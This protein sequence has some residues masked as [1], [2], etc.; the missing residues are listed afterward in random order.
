MIRCGVNGTIPWRAVFLGRAIPV[1]R[2]ELEL[3]LQRLQVIV[4]GGVRRDE[5]SSYM[6]RP[7]H[8]WRAHSREMPDCWF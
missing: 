6:F 4:P 2:A 8:T 3:I 7:P 5:A 1:A